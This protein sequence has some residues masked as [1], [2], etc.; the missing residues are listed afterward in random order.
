LRRELTPQGKLGLQLFLDELRNE[1]DPGG[2]LQIKNY[3]DEPYFVHREVSSSGSRVDI[4]IVAP[5]RFI[6]H[7]EN[8]IRSKESAGQTHKEWT[9]CRSGEKPKEFRWP[10]ATAFSYI[11]RR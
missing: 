7:V 10:I 8:K 9:A 2:K 6:I 4:E 5:Q 3:V 1:L 11:G